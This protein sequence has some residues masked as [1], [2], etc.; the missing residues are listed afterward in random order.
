ML[1]DFVWDPTCLTTMAIVSVLGLFSLLN[2]LIIKCFVRLT[3]CWITA[4]NAKLP[5]YQL[6]V[7]GRLVARLYQ[8]VCLIDLTDPIGLVGLIASA[9]Q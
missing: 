4:I 3:P 2:G 6:A 9:A 5:H 1:A 7:N 8:E